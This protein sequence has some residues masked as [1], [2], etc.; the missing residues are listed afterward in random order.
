MRLGP[1]TTDAE[2]LRFRDRLVACLWDDAEARLASLES[3]WGLEKAAAENS[4]ALYFAAQWAG[5]EYD[6]V[7]LP[8][9]PPCLTSGLEQGLVSSDLEL[10]GALWRAFFPDRA[11]FSIASVESLVAYVRRQVQPLHCQP[12]A[13][14]DEGG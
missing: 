8:L 2:Y 9:A 4:R 13:Q 11:E 12:R 6:E 10:A 14:F 3:E 5:F 1:E 7:C